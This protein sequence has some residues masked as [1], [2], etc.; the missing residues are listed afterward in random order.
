MRPHSQ[1]WFMENKGRQQE[2][3][4]LGNI[5]SGISILSQPAAKFPA[6]RQTMWNQTLSPTPIKPTLVFIVDRKP[7]DL[8][9]ASSSTVMRLH[10]RLSCLSL[11]WIS[12]SWNTS[13]FA[14]YYVD[15]VSWAHFRHT[16]AAECDG[17]EKVNAQQYRILALRIV[18]RQYVQFLTSSA[19][20]LN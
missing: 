17:V 12:T 16:A 5:E 3:G 9:A 10:Q 4:R 18:K 20:S 15:W 1:S 13:L 19:V 14:V 8:T 6:N 7:E 2:A 11:F